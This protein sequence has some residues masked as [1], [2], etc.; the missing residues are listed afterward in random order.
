[1]EGDAEANRKLK[2]IKGDIWAV[3][4]LINECV[5]DFNIKERKV[6]EDLCLLLSLDQL[7]KSVICKIFIT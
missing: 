5:D 6:I 1:M 7:L 4:P 2:I 3:K